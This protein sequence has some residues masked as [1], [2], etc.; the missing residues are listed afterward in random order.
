MIFGA[1]SG[2]RSPPYVVPTYRDPNQPGRKDSPTHEVLWR[3]THRAVRVLIHNRVTEPDYPVHGSSGSG[4]V[5]WDDSGDGGAE[6]PG[7]VAWTADC[8]DR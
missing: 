7:V 6:G 8:G 2:R 5:G 4:E 1:V 3:R